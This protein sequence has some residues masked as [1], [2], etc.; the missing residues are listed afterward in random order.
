MRV[1]KL[2]ATWID[3]YVVQP[4]GI[5]RSNRAIATVRSVTARIESAFAAFANIPYQ[6]APTQ[7][8]IV[9]FLEEI[10]VDYSAGN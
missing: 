6:D 9:C 7:Q 2:T 4:S 3:H 8:E 10:K 1:T 5:A